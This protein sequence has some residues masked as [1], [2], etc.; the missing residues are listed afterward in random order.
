[1][2]W[3]LKCSVGCV[4]WFEICCG[5]VWCVIYIWIWWCARRGVQWNVGVMWNGLPRCGSDLMWNVVWYGMSVAVSDMVWCGMWL[6]C[7]MCDVEW[8]GVEYDVLVCGMLHNARCGKSCD[9][10]WNVWNCGDEECGICNV[11]CDCYEM[12]DVENDAMCWDVRCG[13]VM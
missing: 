11:L 6:K 3:W 5:I 8:C 2:E 1:M 7:K 9:V 12:S 10:M 4:L 13:G